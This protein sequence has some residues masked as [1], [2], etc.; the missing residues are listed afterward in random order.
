MFPQFKSSLSLVQFI[1]INIIILRSTFCSIPL[2]Y[3]VIKPKSR[4]EFICDRLDFKKR[5]DAYTVTTPQQNPYAL[6]VLCVYP[7]RVCSGSLL[8]PDWIITA[9]HCLRECEKILIYAGINSLEEVYNSKY[10]EGYQVQRVDKI[11]KHDMV[12]IALLKVKKKFNFTLTVNKIELPTGPL[13]S[14][15]TKCFFTGF[16]RLIQNEDNKLDNLRKTQELEVIW[17]CDCYYQYWKNRYWPDETEMTMDKR[18]FLCS[19]PRDDYGVCKGDSGAGLVCGENLQ[20]VTISMYTDEDVFEC[21]NLTTVTRQLVCGS[22]NAT[23]VFV[24]MYPLVEW[25]NRVT[26]DPSGECYNFT[27]NAKVSVSSVFT[28]LALYLSNTMF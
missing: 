3:S 27:S 17:P 11:C 14:K 24:A 1:L 12:D 26:C 8:A 23:S 22:G 13:S 25:I 15:V 9:G 7:L 20:A 2:N 4:G 18:N 28:L 10:P 16:G 19:Y 6:M 5:P 21:L